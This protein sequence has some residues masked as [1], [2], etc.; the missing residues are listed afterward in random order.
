MNNPQ[1]KLTFGRLVNSIRQ[2]HDQ[3][4]AQASKRQHQ[5][6]IEEL[7]HWLLYSGVRTERRRPGEIWNPAPG[8]PFLPAGQNRHGMEWL[9]DLYA[10]TD[11]QLGSTD[12][13][14]KRIFQM[15]TTV[16]MERITSKIFLVRKQKVMLD[17]DLAELYGVETKV[18]KQAVKRNIDRFPHDF[19]FELTSDEFQN[20]RSQIV[21]SSWGGTRYIPMAFTEQGVAMLSSVL[22][23]KRAVQVNIQIMRAFTQLRQMLST[24]KDL[25]KKIDAMERKYD[26]Q[27]QVIFEAIK[28]LLE[29]EAT[30][31][32]K[33]GFTVK[34]KQKAYTKSKASTAAGD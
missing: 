30:P 7:G 18:L 26:Q 27:F 4:T 8:E 12:N 19:M 14:R 13:Y 17:R 10:N 3:M 22:R 25:K 1:K 31:K 23:S 29:T 15:P 28:Q 2:I 5:P 33:I 6:D 16:L 34:E 20:L 32:K 24:H 11:R 21:T 9:I